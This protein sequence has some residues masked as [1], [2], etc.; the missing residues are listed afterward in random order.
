MMK[1][2]RWGY[3]YISDIYCNLPPPFCWLHYLL[4][5]TGLARKL[6]DAGLDDDLDYASESVS[7]LNSTEAEM[8]DFEALADVEVEEEVQGAFEIEEAK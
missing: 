8:T 2:S 5:Y 1:V 3:M 4:S 6:R 7:T